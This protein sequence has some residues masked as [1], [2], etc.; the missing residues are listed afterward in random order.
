MDTIVL[1]EQAASIFRVSMIGVR[2]YRQ[3][4][5]E[6]DYSELREGRGGR[7]LSGPV[8]MVQQS[9]DRLPFHNNCYVTRDG[10]T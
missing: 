10:E 9:C 8:G 5:K 7:A 3:C 4:D 6:C 1:E 2:M